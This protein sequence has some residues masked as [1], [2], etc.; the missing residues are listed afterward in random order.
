[1]CGG[2]KTFPEFFKHCC[3]AKH[4]E[5]TSNYNGNYF[6]GIL[7]VII[8]E[9]K[10]FLAKYKSLNEFFKTKYAYETNLTV[11]IL[12]SDSSK[13]YDIKK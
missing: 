13:C 9:K 4:S 7:F 1:M 6:D 12:F 10:F 8:R 5:A 3:K 2:R 11:P